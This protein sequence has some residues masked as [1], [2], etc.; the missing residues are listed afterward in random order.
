MK[1]EKTTVKKR[2]SSE[3]FRISIYVYP[4]Q[5][6][7]IEKMARERGISKRTFFFEMIHMAIQDFKAGRHMS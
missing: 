1:K 6:E 7:W 3:P 5:A 4:N 2:D